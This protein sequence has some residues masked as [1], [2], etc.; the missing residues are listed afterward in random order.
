MDTVSRKKRSEIMSRVKGKDTRPEM[1]VRRMVYGMGYRYRLH[2]PEL[3]GKPDIVFRKRKMVIFVHGCFW[4]RHKNC[5]YARLPKSHV[6]YWEEKLGRNRSRD[7]SNIA[8][9]RRGGWKV[10]V[11]WQCELRDMGS[12]ERRIARFLGDDN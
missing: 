1:V 2:A 5:K 7:K 3:P 4:H 12:L 10:L 9:L 11:V 8:R 6:S